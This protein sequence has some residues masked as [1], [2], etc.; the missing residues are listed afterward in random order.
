MSR[1]AMAEFMADILDHSNLRPEGVTVELTPAQGWEDYEITALI[2]VRDDEFLPLDEESV[3]WFY[4]DDEDGGLASNGTCDL[5][6][7]LDGDCEWSENEFYETEDDGN[8]IVKFS[9][10]PGK[11][12]TFYA[13]VG[14]RDGDEFDEDT[15]SFGKSEARSDMGVAEIS[16]TS[17]IAS[18]AAKVTKETEEYDTYI[19]DLDRVSAVTL[20]AQLQDV[21]GNRLRREGIE[22]EIDVERFSRLLDA[23]D[24][25]VTEDSGI[26]VPTPS[27][28]PGSAL[29]SPDTVKVLTD[30]NGV[31][32]YRL[33]GPA[34]RNTREDDRLDV[35]TFSTTVADDCCTAEIGVAWSEAP[36][37]LSTG[38]AH[39]R[40]V[41]F[42]Q[43]R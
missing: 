25:T 38:S 9:A 28:S 40:V 30:R 42:P 24:V 14:L 13:W 12:M 31:V 37:G 34:S 27:L 5:D 39:Y 21:D 22:V 17:N 19:V 10:T 11:T 18:T 35:V 6:V 20:R 1:A 8:L 32:T 4:T 23:D 29:A 15:A 26:D 36:P 2:T 41:P 16:I 43:Q 7:I 33:T 3:D